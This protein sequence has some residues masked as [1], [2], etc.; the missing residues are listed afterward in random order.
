MNRIEEEV[1]KF[2]LIKKK[3]KNPEID[4]LIKRNGKTILCLLNK[5]KIKNYNINQRSSLSNSTN[6]INSIKKI[7]MTKKDHVLHTKDK[8]KFYTKKYDEDNT[9]KNHKNKEISPKIKEKLNQNKIYPNQNISYSQSFPKINYIENS[10]KDNMSRPYEGNINLLDMANGVIKPQE[11]QKIFENERNVIE[12]KKKKE[13][14]E[15]KNIISDNEIEE[16]LDFDDD[17]DIDKENNKEQDKI[18]RNNKNE[19]LNTKIINKKESGINYSL[20]FNIFDDKNMFKRRDNFFDD[21]SNSDNN[22]SEKKNYS[23]E[24]DKKSIKYYSNEK[25]KKDISKYSSPKER[26]KI[27]N[28][29][30][31]YITPF[32]GKENNNNNKEND[33]LNITGSNFN[34]IY[35]PIDEYI[36]LVVYKDNNKNKHTK[37]KNEEQPKNINEKFLE[38]K[39]N[40][41]EN[42]KNPIRKSSLFSKSENS[43][44]MEHKNSFTKKNKK[45]IL[46]DEDEEEQYIETNNNKN[47]INNMIFTTP[48]IKN[49]PNFNNKETILLNEGNKFILKLESDI[50]VNGTK[51]LTNDNIK[52]MKNDRYSN[53]SNDNIKSMKK[54]RYSNS[55]TKNNITPNNITINIDNSKEII[56]ENKYIL[57]NKNKNG[58]QIKSDKND[59]NKSNYDISCLNLISNILTKIEE[60]IF[61][62]KKEKNII[63]KCFKIINTINNDHDTLQKK[64][65][66][67]SGILKILYILFSYLTE[68]KISKNYYNEISQILEYA[69]IYYKNVKKY[70]V[71]IN[72]IKSFYKKKMAFKYIYSK[73]ALKNYDDS[74]LKELTKKTN[75]DNNNINK[76]IKLI[77]T[78]KRYQKTSLYLFRE[79][80]DFREKISSSEKTKDIINLTKKYE[81]CPANIQMS[82][83]F[84]SYNRLFSHFSLILTFSNDYKTFLNYEE[85]KK[86]GISNSNEMKGKIVQNSNCG[87]NNK[88][89]E[90]NK[91]GNKEMENEKTKVK[92]KN[93]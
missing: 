62:E 32:C 57:I 79:F 20:D 24:E 84:M 71:S 85:S 28:D 89:K 33:L 48:N 64:K 35:I 18:E 86:N 17:D 49:S 41:K 42:H 7:N 82:P 34:K 93:Y 13:N 10:I 44:N 21:E 25:S 45:I 5:Q 30:D 15:P 67:Y 8:N 37:I 75:Y 47:N 65:N 27:E 19:S 40:N 55:S 9:V 46:D 36:D 50:K 14:I 22:H 6:D 90:H 4:E 39:R 77:K 58:S 38:K 66:L 53:S 2:I 80:K 12:A 61:K 63:N 70:D 76:Q 11:I 74:C 72:N 59:N 92:I 29:N 3:L 60:K 52:S 81:S 68:K 56:K 69:Y 1:N 83:H 16:D 26:N 91:L 23:D 78:Y 73:L 51:S 54:D 43:V 31:K 88:K 87:V